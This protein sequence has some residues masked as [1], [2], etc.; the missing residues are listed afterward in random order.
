MK[1]EVTVMVP[2]KWFCLKCWQEG[3]CQIEGK[4]ARLP[5]DKIPDVHLQHQAMVW[6]FGGTCTGDFREPKRRVIPRKKKE[7]VV[8]LVF[9]GEGERIG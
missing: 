5:L 6:S 9:D 1:K 7:P 3:E 2:V 4:D 8:D